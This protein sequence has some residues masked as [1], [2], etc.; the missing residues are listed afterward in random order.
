MPVVDEIAA[1]GI[2]PGD[3]ASQLAAALTTQASTIAAA[4]ITTAQAATAARNASFIQTGSAATPSATTDTYGTAVTFSPDAGFV[5]LTHLT[6]LKLVYGSVG[7]ETVTVLLTATFDDETTA[8]LNPPTKTASATEF[9]S[10]DLTFNVSGED[11]TSLLKSGHT[12]ETLD[13][14][15]KSS[16]PSSTATVTPTLVGVEVP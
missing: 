10:E 12:I 1:G 13:V 2:H 11:L 14:Q 3:F 7:S 4:A 9:L 16:I 8:T 15:V 5:G 6:A